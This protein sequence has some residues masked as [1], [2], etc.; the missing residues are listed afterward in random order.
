M[1]DMASCWERAAVKPSGG[2]WGDDDGTYPGDDDGTYPGDDDGTYPGDDDGTYPG[3]D[4]GTYPGDDDGTYP[5]DDDGTYPGDD[6]GHGQLLGVSRREAERHHT[7][8][9]HVPLRAAQVVHDRRHPAG[10]HNQLSQL[11]KDT[12]KY[13]YKIHKKI[14]NTVSKNTVKNTNTLGN[15]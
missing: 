13:S 8:Q 12:K 1:T 5:G 15:N 10:V 9:R 14:Q 3:D 11:L 7:R 4:D 6:D 2:Q